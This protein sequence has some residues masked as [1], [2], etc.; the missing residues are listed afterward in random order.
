MPNTVRWDDQTVTWDGQPVYWGDPTPPPPGTIQPGNLSSGSALTSP[1][2]E[3]VYPFDPLDLQL[4]LVGD[5]VVLTW[6]DIQ[7]PTATHAV[8]FRRSGTDTTPF[9]PTTATELHR[10]SR[11]LTQYVDH[12]S[13]PGDWVYQVYPLEVT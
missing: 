10:Q 1:T 4:E 13:G 8:I 12:T 5:S 7:M 3:K 6:T 11:N 9:D 2:L